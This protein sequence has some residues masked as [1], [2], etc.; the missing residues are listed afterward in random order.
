[1]TTSKAP[2]LPPVNAD[3]RRVAVGKFERANQ[4]IATGNFDYGIHLLM[5]CCKIDP[6]S[7]P[8][9]QK[10]R[11]TERRKYHNNLRGSMFAWLTCWPVRARM[12][13]AMGARDYL[14]ALEYGERILMRN[15][16]DVGA[17]MDMAEAAE[18]LGQLDLAV[19]TLEQARQK[20]A[21][22]PH[23]NR[24]LARLYENRGNFTQAIA[25][26]EL[27][28]KARP[29]DVEAQHKIKDLAADD[30]I[31]RGQYHATIQSAEAPA[32]ES[33]PPTPAPPKEDSTQ[34]T[35][36]AAWWSHESGTPP[37][38]TRTKPATPAPTPNPVEAPAVNDRLERE[39][40]P[41]RARLQNDP[42]SP[43]LYL[44]L[45]AVYRRGDDLDKA[46]AVLHEGLGP[47]GNAFELSVQLADIDIEPFRR[48]LAI[49]E[50]KLKAEPNSAELRRLRTRLRKEINTRE[51]ELY[52]QKAD[53]YPTEM[54][55][56]YEVGVRLLRLGQIDEAI[57]ELQASRGDPRYRWQSL[58]ALGQCFKARNN[59][60]L[61]ERNFE[62]ALKNL[63]GGEMNHRKE[64]LYELAV[65]CAEANDL[66]KAIDMG[67]ELANIDFSYR[68][69]G[70][71]LDE[72]HTRAQQDDV[73][74]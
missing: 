52:R 29:G 40:A 36:A 30:T 2:I 55:H 4:V 9:R 31:A 43:H 63:P 66:G 51:L 17:Q 11:A 58:L 45:A 62:E 18:M 74:E 28:R 35:P 8:Y 10:L 39:A 16:W 72:W 21:L 70:R 59:W 26:W 33:A 65:G 54:S 71:L 7:L 50:E 69:I 46:R 41:I 61:A 19:W 3:H 73:S 25:L 64:I 60:R 47:T 23:L 67:T 32:E 53:R 27:I 20:Q 49:T 12:K 42:A 13:A 14:K 24:A 34:V 57:S 56:R 68:D 6:G 37:P 15:P 5:D 1:M 38:R 22:D 44:Q 48:N